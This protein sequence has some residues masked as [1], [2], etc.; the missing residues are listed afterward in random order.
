MRLVYF[1]WVRETVGCGEETV[2]PPADVRTVG[3][4][5]DWLSHRGAPYDDLFAARDKLRLAVN[6]DYADWTAP[7][8]TSDEIAFFPPVTGG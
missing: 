1:A 8:A 4:L 2:S 6:Q 3:D 5:A 7:V